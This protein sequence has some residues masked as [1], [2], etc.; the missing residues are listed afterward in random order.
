M[1]PDLLALFDAYT[2]QQVTD[3]TNA[4]KG[5]RVDLA[6]PAGSLFV[7]VGVKPTRG[8]VRYS[9]ALERRPGDLVSVEP[10]QLAAIKAG[11]DVVMT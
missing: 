2:G 5:Q 8:E 4:P 9:R 7:K 10:E 3:W 1:R 6:L 11:R